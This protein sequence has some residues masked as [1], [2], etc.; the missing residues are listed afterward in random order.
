MAWM[1]GPSRSGSIPCRRR[2]RWILP[3]RSSCGAGTWSR[4]R[5]WPGR[6]SSRSYR[7]EGAERQAE[8][9]RNQHEGQFQS[10]A[11]PAG[12]IW[13]NSETL[14]KTKQNDANV[15]Q[16]SISVGDV[17]PFGCC[18]V[19]LDLRWQRGR[20]VSEPGSPISTNRGSSQGPAALPSCVYVSKP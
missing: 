16:I 19:L 17:Q 11:A 5:R 6:G 13:L 12:T 3:G 15:K 8:W 10:P 4:S 14:K 9:V 18:A 2:R 1:P 20:G 7:L